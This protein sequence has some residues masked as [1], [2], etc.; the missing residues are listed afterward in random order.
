MNRRQ[1]LK[2]SLAC[3]AVAG[4]PSLA[5]AQTGKTIRVVVGFAAGTTLDVVTR[6]L[7]EKMRPILNQQILIDNRPGAGG[8]IAAEV[9]KTAPAD[10]TVLMTVPIVV[11]VLA[12]MVYKINY[13][14]DTDMVPV[15]MMC[16]F[17]FGLGVK[18]DFPA[19]NVAEIVTWLKANPNK[20]NFGL[21]SPGSL[22]HFF[23]LLLGRESGVELV[24]VPFSGGAPLQ[25]AVMG[26]DIPLG[27]DVVSEWV[28]N[29]RAGKVRVLATSGATRSTALPDVPTFKEQGYP[30]IIGNGWFA[31]Y[32]PP[33]T[34]AVEVDRINKALNTAL[35]AP[36]VVGRFQDLAIEPSP[37]T[38]ADLASRMVKDK[39]RWGPLVKAS[40]FRGD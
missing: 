15:G 11:P 3:T 21:P 8:R 25:M 34:P 5:V 30:E 36:D 33:G 1:V 22:P 13:N 24:H 38:P 19:K 17:F 37:G 23:G 6:L 32:A 20:A 39:A 35:A 31:M 9:F 16:T 2:T 18:P 7:A 28:Q 14:P 4:A 40:G 10:G 27:M 26:G 29:H 12:P